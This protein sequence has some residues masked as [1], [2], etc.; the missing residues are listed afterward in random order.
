[1][2]VLGDVLHQHVGC[3]EPWYISAS[4][5]QHGKLDGANQ[6][7]GILV[8]HASSIKGC[9][10]FGQADQKQT[11]IS[12]VRCDVSVWGLILL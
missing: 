5:K 7:S 10:A 6:S 8:K 12:T 2:L 3:Y 11:K 9:M 4:D 1:M